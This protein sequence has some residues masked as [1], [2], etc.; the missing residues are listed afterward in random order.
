MEHQNKLSLDF[1]IGQGVTGHSLETFEKLLVCEILLESLGS[2][3]GQCTEDLR[4]GQYLVS[5]EYPLAITRRCQS[6]A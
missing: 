4:C 1:G 3:F 2:V 5:H 6:Q